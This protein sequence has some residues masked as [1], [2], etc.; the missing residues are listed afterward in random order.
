M[1]RFGFAGEVRFSLDDSVRYTVVDVSLQ[2]G[3]IQFSARCVGM[4]VRNVM[5]E[6]DFS[7]VVEPAPDGGGGH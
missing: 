1:T 4:A 3:P 7:T 6:T 5:V 2:S